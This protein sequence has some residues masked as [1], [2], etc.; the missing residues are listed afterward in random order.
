V[1]FADFDGDGWMDIYVANDSV[2][3]FPYRNNR[4][5]I[6][7]VSL[8]AGV[9][10]NEDGKTFAAWASILRLRQRWPP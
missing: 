10:F 6:T 4:D 9:G 1:A 2:Q 5:G 3:C 7:D 8:S